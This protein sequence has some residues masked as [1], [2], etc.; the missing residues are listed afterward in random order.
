MNQGVWHG[1][2]QSLK[3]SVHL[4][5]WKLNSI[6]KAFINK[7]GIKKNN[8]LKIPLIYIHIN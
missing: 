5:R 6:Q 4:K 8:E 7:L 3:L 1:S 2:Q